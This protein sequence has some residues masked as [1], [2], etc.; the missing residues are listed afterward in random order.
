LE[1]R[2]VLYIPSNKNNLLS[3]GRWA[4]SGRQYSGDKRLL[5]LITADG[6]TIAVGHNTTNNLCKMQVSVRRVK[7]P[8]TEHKAFATTTSLESWE[9][10]H[11]RLGHVSYS[12]L[13]RLWEKNLVDGF[14]VDMSTPT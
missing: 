8:L 9:T 4:A 1:L 14:T 7:N 6:K 3:L 10:W 11:K 12:G 2:N 5:R 13:K